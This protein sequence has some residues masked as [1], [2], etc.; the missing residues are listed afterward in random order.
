MGSS[1]LTPCFVLL[2]CLLLSLLNCTLTRKLSSFYPSESLPHPAGG[3][4][5]ERLCAGVK[6]CKDPLV[7]PSIQHVC[8]MQS[9][10]M[11]VG[12]EGLVCLFGGVV[13][14]FFLFKKHNSSLI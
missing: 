10:T 14:V 5:S 2:V 7:L 11:V 6:P 9:W 3:A 1:E 13:L 8:M 4:V 12:C